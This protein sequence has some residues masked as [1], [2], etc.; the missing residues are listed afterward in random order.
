MNSEIKYNR[1]KYNKID[2]E[3]VN[4]SLKS[5]LTDNKGIKRYKIK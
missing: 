3:Y 2:I 5:W 1:I 4:I